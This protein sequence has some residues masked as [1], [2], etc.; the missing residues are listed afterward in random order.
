[1]EAN[2]RTDEDDAEPML[3][4]QFQIAVERT[5]IRSEE[6]I[7]ACKAV[8]VDSKTQQD[9]AQ[10]LNVDRGHISRA[11]NK[12]REKWQEICK[13]QRW[14]YLPIAL[15]HSTMQLVLKMQH[16]ELE[17]YRAGGRRKP[18]RK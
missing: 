8:L 5:Q 3:P 7:A 18:R 4:E 15:P 16:E 2:T 6:L 11:V 14:E 13:D 1:M 9:V 17:K 10:Q 12:I